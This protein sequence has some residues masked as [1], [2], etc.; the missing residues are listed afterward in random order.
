[1]RYLQKASSGTLLCA[2]KGAQFWLFT[3]YG[4]DV[5]DGLTSQQKWVLKG[6][7]SDEKAQ[8]I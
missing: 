8:R 3:I 6:M 4:K 1:M 2:D 7:S 5:E